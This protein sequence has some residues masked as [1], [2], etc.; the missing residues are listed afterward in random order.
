MDGELDK[1]KQL[2]Y[3]LG[4]LPALTTLYAHIGINI[5]PP[6]HSFLLIY[7]SE[8]WTATTREFQIT[9]SIS[10]P[11]INNVMIT[12]LVP[13]TVTVI[14]AWLWQ[15]LEADEFA[16]LCVCLPL[17]KSSKNQR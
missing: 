6:R 1:T 2:M 16:W 9:L 4:I 14:L 3:V 5:K 7:I 17:L 11:N 13:E 15:L 8:L 12:E 10:T